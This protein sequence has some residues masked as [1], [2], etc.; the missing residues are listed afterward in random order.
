MRE[1]HEKPRLPLTLVLTS[2]LRSQIHSIN[3]MVV[4]GCHPSK[5]KHRWINVHHGSAFVPDHPRWNWQLLLPAIRRA[6]SGPGCYERH[7]HPTLVMGSFLSPQRERADMFMG[8]PQRRV[9][10]IVPKKE[11]KRILSNAKAFQVVKN[12]AQALV[13]A[14]DQRGIGL[15]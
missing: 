12:I 4:S 3:R 11:D 15:S 10:A 9:A 5:C 2:K 14:F 8:R 7:P 1:M 6:W 13:H